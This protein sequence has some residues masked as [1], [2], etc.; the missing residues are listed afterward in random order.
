MPAPWASPSSLPSP[1]LDPD[2]E[3]GLHADPDLGERASQDL[4]RPT[5]QGSLSSP[6]GADRGGVRG[7][8]LGVPIAHGREE[9]PTLC[10]GERSWGWSWWAS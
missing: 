6:G 10:Q 7:T 5:P 1:R 9:R 8:G 3:K 4:S 2:S